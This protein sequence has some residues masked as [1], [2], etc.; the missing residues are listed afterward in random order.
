MLKIQ[1]MLT[2]FLEKLFLGIKMALF[3]F[4]AI[5][6]IAGF[7]GALITYPFNP[8]L[9]GL[10]LKVFIIGVFSLIGIIIIIW[11]DSK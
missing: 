11:A 8:S 2:F 10:L 5:C 4:A 1:K 9:G 7:W 6:T 3:I